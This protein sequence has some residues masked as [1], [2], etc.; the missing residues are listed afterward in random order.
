MSDTLHCTTITR[1]S[2]RF[3]EDYL[4]ACRIC[5]AQTR[6]ILDLGESPPANAFNDAPTFAQASFPLVLEV[7][8]AC[9]NLQLHDCMDAQVLYRNYLYTTP[10]SQTL[11]THYEKLFSYL[12]QRRYIGPDSFVLEVGSNSGLFLQYLKPR[13]ARVLGIDPAANI[14]DVARAAGIDTLCDFFAGAAANAIRAS[15]G[16]PDA[17]VGRHCF[18]HN[19]DPHIMIAAAAQLLAD[20]GS[21]IIEN[22]YALNTIENNEFDQIY[23]EHM[24]YYSIR[25]VT[26][27]LALHGLFLADVFLSPVHGGSIVFVAR[28]QSSDGRAHES[29]AQHFQAERLRLTT[30][31]LER[32]SDSAVRIRT[33]LAALVTELATAGKS[34]YTYGASAKGN[35]LLNYVGLTH[36]YI[37]Y[38]VDSTPVKQG[39]YL[40]KSNIEVVSEEYARA[41]PPDYFLL[42][43]W[44]YEDEIISKVRR[45]GNHRSKF[46]VPIPDVRIVSG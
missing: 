9:G 13:V 34:I 26:A 35:T 29:V 40:P 20:T 4:M 10:D 31:A 25:S 7:C 6:R 22:A 27:L 1:R 23:H 36:E 19:C 41:A 14:C 8:V 30:A 32:F 38:C 21:L 3:E 17:I 46:I 43:A 5:K 33:Q 12:A 16:V 42:T 39:K 11:R 2:S 15:Y 28:K 45:S 44:N 24:F 18:A 37:R